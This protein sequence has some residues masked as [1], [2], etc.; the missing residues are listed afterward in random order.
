MLLQIQLHTNKVAL[1]VA[2][3]Q[4]FVNHQCNASCTMDRVPSSSSY[5]QGCSLRTLDKQESLNSQK[6][7][8]L[9]VGIFISWSNGSWS[10]ERC[11]LFGCTWPLFFIHVELLGDLLVVLLASLTPT[12]I[13]DQQIG[14]VE[15]ALCMS[16]L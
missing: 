1:E 9:V 15:C 6:S 5:S 12:S 16:S 11:D 7:I 10:L 3:H 2:H 8:F 14:Y 13:L 4:I